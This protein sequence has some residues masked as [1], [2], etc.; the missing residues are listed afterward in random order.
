MVV[1]LTT[2]YLYRYY[3]LKTIGFTIG[4]TPSCRKQQQ[5]LNKTFGPKMKA[6]HHA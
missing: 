6:Y 5:Q 1:Y 4:A 2:I 3:I